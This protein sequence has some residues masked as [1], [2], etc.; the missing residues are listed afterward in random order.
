MKANRKVIISTF[1]SNVNR[2]QQIVEACIKQIENWLCSA[3][4]W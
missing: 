4:V 3:E 1:A 2:V